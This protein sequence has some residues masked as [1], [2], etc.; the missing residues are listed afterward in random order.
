LSRS[1]EAIVSGSGLP[2]VDIIDSLRQQLIL[3]DEVVLEAP[4]GAGKTTLVPLAL[5]DQPWL[6]GKKI[7]MLE[8]RR[9]AARAAAQRMASML[10]ESVGET[11]GYRMRLD[12][13][14][15]AATRIEVITEGILTRILHHDP[16]LSGVGLLV[17]DEFHERNLDSDLGLAL[18]LQGRD[19]Y[20]DAAQRLKL[21]VMS[22][23]LDGCAISAMLEN[24][25][26]IQSSGRMYPVTVHYRDA[27]VRPEALLPELV[28]TLIRLL[29]NDGGSI[30]VFLPGRA[31]IVTVA[32]LLGERLGPKSCK[33]ASK[34]DIAPLYGGLSLEQQQLAIEPAATGRRKV[35]LAT[36]IAETSL[37]IDGIGI[38]VDAGL[39]REPVFDPGTGMTRLKTQAVSQASSEQRSGRAGRL[40]PGDCYRL[41][42]KSRQSQLPPH[43]AA[44]ILQ[45]D[46]AP[47]ALQLLAWG[48]D[49]PD[50]L[51]WLDPPPSA[52]FVQA[53]QLL[54]S[55]GAC[56][57]SGAEIWRLTDHGERMAAMPLHPRLAHMLLVASDYQLQP[58]ACQVAALLSERDQP[59]GQGADLWRR[60]SCLAGYAGASPALASWRQR[61]QRQAR[62]YQ[63]FC[64]KASQPPN[65]SEHSALGMLLASAY[66]DRI[67]RRRSGT[68]GAYQLSNGRGATLNQDDPLVNAQWL[69]VGELGG[70]VGH[71]RDR[72]YL[73]AELDCELFAGPLAAQLRFHEQ[74]YWDAS[75]QRIVARR[76][77]KLG[78]L[79]LDS[80]PLE[81]IDPLAH[82]RA[83]WDMLQQR[84]LDALP[85][86]KTLRQ[87]QAR[88]LLLREHAMPAD[89]PAWPDV[90]DAALLASAQ[91]WLLPM[92]GNIGSLAQLQKLDLAGLLLNML[93]W[94][95]PRQ[96]DAL[97]PQRFLV[98]SGSSVEI[99]YCQP[100]PVLAVKL[101]EMFGCDVNPSIVN[102]RVS[103]L[104]HLLSPARR[105]LQVTRDLAGFWRGSY[106]Q[107]KK[108]MKGRYPKHPWPDDPLTAAPTRYAKRRQS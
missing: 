54:A 14:V 27:A 66:P 18:A 31:E 6:T 62:Q 29:N 50:E 2:V 100:V 99:D 73:A 43:A 60:W 102:G 96:L 24:A 10:G 55:F 23:T 3:R 63:S 79:V 53:L 25:P 92:L 72:I 84:G 17:F 49:Q 26:L 41:W 1:I 87:W 13:R 74:V 98:P 51:S 12:T 37:T 80:V 5:L 61:I 104:L 57:T 77:R 48:V 46:L 21:L 28:A 34:V 93:P 105:P 11:V 35:V 56:E 82:Q 33:P 45:A 22:A 95:L 7:I 19:I 106:A 42:S 16:A 58:M 94:P 40:G 47:L 64:P 75:A 89:E 103:L 88:V 76:Q 39:V 71:S 36:N 20:G 85:W 4:P 101:Q 107:V 68:P 59:G 70:R 78:A 83:W 8:P 52:P 65:I 67:A 86:N 44:E 97:A 108:D 9:L 91:H 81:P 30:L 38:V 32:R 90:S 15:S 69:A